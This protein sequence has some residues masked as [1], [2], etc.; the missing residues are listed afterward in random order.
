MVSEN[1]V[2][3]EP[4]AVYLQLVTVRIH[5]S[6]RTAVVL[7]VYGQRWIPDIVRVFELEFVKRNGLSPHT[8]TKANEDSREHNHAR[9]LFYH[10]KEQNATL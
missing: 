7:T 8:P 5:R 10:R 9:D 1:P 6:G 4:C 3:A 2:R